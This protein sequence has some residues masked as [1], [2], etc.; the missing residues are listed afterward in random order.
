[1]TRRAALG[2]LMAL[3]APAQPQAALAQLPPACAAAKEPLA[4]LMNWVLT[5]GRPETLP[6]KILGLAG[7]TDLPVMQK[8]YRNPATHL[9]HAVDVAVADDRCELVFIIDDVGNVTTWVTD[10]SGAITRTFHLAQGENE[11]VP[12]ERYVSEYETIKSYFLEKVP[13]P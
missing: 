11:I 12:N 10:T 9:I 4:G 1:M 6:A 13:P 7:E 3:A 2:V 5:E 8:A